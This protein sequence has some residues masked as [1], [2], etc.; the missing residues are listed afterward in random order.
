MIVNILTQVTKF[1]MKVLVL[2]TMMIKTLISKKGIFTRM[3]ILF[4]TLTLFHYRS[5]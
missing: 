4:A 2:Q 1:E 3:Y 5:P